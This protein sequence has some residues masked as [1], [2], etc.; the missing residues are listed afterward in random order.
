ME[1]V[2]HMLKDG[3]IRAG[4]PKPDFSG[5]IEWDGSAEEIVVRIEREW[6][7]LDHEPSFD[8]IVWFDITEKGQE[9]LKKLPA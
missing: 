5:F 9:Y 3:L 4:E 8:D 7:E 2:S 1:I 6:D